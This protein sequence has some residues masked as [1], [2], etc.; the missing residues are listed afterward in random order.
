[1][2]MAGGLIKAVSSG[3]VTGAAFLLGAPAIQAALDSIP[4]FVHTGLSVA[5]GLMPAI[6]LALLAR[7]LFAKNV[8]VFFFLGFVVA[9]YLN[10]PVTGMAILWLIIAAIMVN[11][12]RKQEQSVQAANEGGNDDDDF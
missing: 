1:M 3:I 9:A 10:V 4:A 6:G 8:V 5:N 11:V 7:L 12:T 2:Q